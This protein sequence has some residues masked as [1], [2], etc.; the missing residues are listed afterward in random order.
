MEMVKQ[1]HW[2]ERDLKD[3]ISKA[4]CFVKELAEG[5]ILGLEQTQNEINLTPFLFC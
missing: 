1:S 4:A 5:I 3:L 2:E